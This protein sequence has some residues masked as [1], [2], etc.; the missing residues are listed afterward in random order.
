[1]FNLLNMEIRIRKQDVVQTYKLKDGNGAVYMTISGFNVLV[2]R[3]YML[4]I[5]KRVS[6]K[7]TPE[8]L[9]KIA[10]SIDYPTERK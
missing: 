3:Q 7:V 9:V 1:M 10:E 2:F 8:L 6:D 5:D 4:S